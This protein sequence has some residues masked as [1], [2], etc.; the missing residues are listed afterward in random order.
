M[1]IMVESGAARLDRD[2]C[3]S[4]CPRAELNTDSERALKPSSTSMKAET[5]LM[6]ILLANWTG[7]YIGLDFRS[8]LVRAI[9]KLNSQA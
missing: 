8:P 6:T 2:E 9:L 4:I 5:L 7:E 1:I 3:A